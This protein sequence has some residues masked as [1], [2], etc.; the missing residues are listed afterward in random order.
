MHNNLMQT[1]SYEFVLYL[2]FIALLYSYVER[3]SVKIR[4]S[5]TLTAFMFIYLRR[6]RRTILL[7]HFY[8]YLKYGERFNQNC[9]RSQI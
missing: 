8:R 3:K 5:D 6:L 1:I 2:C 9:G 7:L 4:S